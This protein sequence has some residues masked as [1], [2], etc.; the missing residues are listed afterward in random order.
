MNKI[1]TEFPTLI[2]VVEI[3]LELG[4]TL[5]P[6]KVPSPVDT[7]LQEDRTKTIKFSGETTSSTPEL[8][9]LDPDFIA[10]KD[11]KNR[12]LRKKLT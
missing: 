12:K 1:L 11:K 5:V 2:E 3:K 7:I 9:S 6:E 8:T 10:E 4:S